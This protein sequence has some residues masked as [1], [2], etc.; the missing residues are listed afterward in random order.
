MH[1]QAHMRAPSAD[2]VRDH[3]LDALRTFVRQD[4]YLL[5][6]DLHERTLTHKLAEYLQPLFP[7]WNVDCEYNRDGHDP[8][9]VRFA[10]P[11]PQNEDEGSNVFPD[12]IIHR[13]GTNDHNLLIIEAKKSRDGGQG[14]DERD[15]QKVE[16]FI[17]DLRYRYGALVVFHIADE[18]TPFHALMHASG[19]W[20]RLGA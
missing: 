17:R 5:S 11:P 6:H 10:P 9:R 2:A 16:A 13:R 20:N 19:E 18:V 12:I 4:S 8:K 14:I 3:L 15:R 1:D 7:D